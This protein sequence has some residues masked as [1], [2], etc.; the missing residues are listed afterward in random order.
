MRDESGQTV[1]LVVGAHLRAEREHR[2]LAYTLRDRLAA[3]I[4]PDGPLAPLVCTDLW[5]LNQPPLRARPTI[6]LG[7]PAENALTAYLV[8]KLPVATA[9]E[10]L[11]A[12]QLDLEFID[13]QACIWGA[14]EDATAAAVDVFTDRYL[15]DFLRESANRA[16]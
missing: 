11:F 2:P 8:D 5:Y 10:G 16:A 3:M 14:D 6:S 13:L 12:V 4:G 9:V 7:S 15:D 1:L